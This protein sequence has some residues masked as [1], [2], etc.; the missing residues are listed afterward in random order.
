MKRKLCLGL[1]LLGLLGGAGHLSAQIT[2]VQFNQGATTVNLQSQR[3]VPISPTVNTNIGS[4]G[5]GP[6]QS[7]SYLSTSPPTTNQFVGFLTFGA[8]SATTNNALLQKTNPY[9]QGTTPFSLTV[10]TN[11]QLPVSSTPLFDG[12]SI[13]LRRA[14][15]GAPYLSRASS[16]L[17]GSI[18]PPPTNDVNGILLNNNPNYWLPQPYPLGGYAGI[19]ST[20]SQFYYSPYAGAVFAT[21]TGPINITWVTFQRWPQNGLPAYTNLIGSIPGNYI[22]S[23]LTNSDNTV[24][25]LY[26]ASYIVSASPVKTPQHMYWTEGL[27][28]TLGYKVRVPSGQI[29]AMNVIYNDSF[30]ASVSTPVPDLGSNEILPTNTLWYDGSAEIHAY[31]AAGRVFVEFLGAPNGNGGNQ[32]LGFEIVDVAIS[33]PTVQLTNNLGDPLTPYADGAQGGGL[34][35]RAARCR[36]SQSVLL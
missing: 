20:N 16:F 13:V 29:S 33:P 27:Y 18:V 19:H 22:P 23:F 12:S 7:S 25:E 30:P 21:K 35:C 34:C 3:G 26:T 2:F 1:C 14:A 8:V 4:D 10:A 36:R 24:S 15:V 6:V 9:L 28:S 17:F 32:Y 31:N 5:R 11:M